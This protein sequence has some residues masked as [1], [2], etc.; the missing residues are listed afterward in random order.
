MLSEVAILIIVL[1]CLFGTPFLGHAQQ[2]EWVVPQEET[3]VENPLSG[4]E[5][6]WMKGQK[7]FKKICW[8]CHGISGEGDGPA[9]LNLNPKPKN[10]TDPELQ[11]QTDGALFWKMS[12]GRGAMAPYK[13]SLTETQRWQLVNY[14]RTLKNSQ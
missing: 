12:N 3:L 10:L 9:S 1:G 14:I 4:D 13:M 5:E 2:E 11:K 7:L 8:T 6:A